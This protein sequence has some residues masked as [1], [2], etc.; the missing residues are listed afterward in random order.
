MDARPLRVLFVTDAFAP[1]VGGV[2]RVCLE[3]ARSLTRAG[4]AVTVLSKR[5]DGAPAQED[6]GGVHVVR[7]SYSRAW[8]PWTYATSI[9]AS[10]RE[11]EHAHR[12]TPFDVVHGHLTLSWL[13][14]SRW[15]MARGVRTVTSF[16]GPWHREYAIESEALAARPWPYP[17]Y[18]GALLRAQR[19][20]QA[21]VLR[22]ADARVV[23]SR[24]SIAR[25]RE[26]APE[27]ADA[28]FRVV[29]GGIDP[30][31]FRPGSDAP[32]ARRTH[33]RQLNLPED[34]FLVLTVRRLVK[35]MGVA[36]LVR[37]ARFLAD[38]GRPVHLVLAGRGPEADAL[39]RLV[40]EL[41]L[42]DRVT[43]VG[44][45]PEPVLPDFYRACDLFVLPTV[46]EE[47]F[48]LII[49]EAAACGCPVVA[50]PVGSI[51]EVLGDLSPAFLC[52]AATP[53]AIAAKIQWARDHYEKISWK[54][55][56]EIAQ[57]VR[58]EYAWDRL[59]EKLVAVY[60]GD[61]G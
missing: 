35:R 56:R 44:F 32:D 58:R 10:R 47:N 30:E 28:D 15:F 46:A 59:A 34:A 7:Y 36:N 21:A 27:L 11:A 37:A 39:G 14:P 55:A 8:T 51:P 54:F 22:R 9:A 61:A 52:D 24:Y 3:L 45:V 26:L 48:G 31:V 41:G 43:F 23:L 20:M 60:R 57:R 29:P 18:L 53:E 33:R 49:L 38:A 6:M 42:A 17:A 16:Y 13:G 5:V 2:E 4:H 12:A 1:E 19:A 40:G 50:T 25:A